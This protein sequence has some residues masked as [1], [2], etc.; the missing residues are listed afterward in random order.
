MVS[1][2]NKSCD[3]TENA[4]NMPQ[5]FNGGKLK[6]LRMRK[7]WTLRDLSD[8]LKV[9]PS[10]IMRWEDGTHKPHKKLVPRI[11]NLFVINPKKLYM[12]VEE[13]KTMTLE[14]LQSVLK[15]GCQ[16]LEFKPDAKYLIYFEKSMFSASTAHELARAIDEFYGGKVILVAGYGKDGIKVFE[17]KE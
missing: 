14:E 13:I 9:A 1:S 8:K 4:T 12:E 5:Q 17:I 16:V 10:A 3:R 11:A 15:D 7:G 2:V 6:E